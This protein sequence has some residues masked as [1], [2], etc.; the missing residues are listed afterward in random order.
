MKRSL[1]QFIIITVVWMVP[2]GASDAEPASSINLGLGG[3]NPMPHCNALVYTIEYEHPLTRTVTILGRGSRVNYH[4]DDGTSKK[5]GGNIRGLDVGPVLFVRWHAWGLLRRVSRILG[6]KLDIPPGHEQA[7]GAAGQV[8][9]PFSQAEH[10][11]WRP[12][13]DPEHE[14]FNH[15]GGQPRQILHVQF[16]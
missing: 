3:I 13:P 12:Y 6:R 7:Y 16:V 4:Y 5:E 14:R 10:R 1:A 11:I 8:K 2:F 9:L 15:A